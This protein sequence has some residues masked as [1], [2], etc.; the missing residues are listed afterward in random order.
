MNCREFTEF[1]NLYFDG[2]LAAAERA[3]FD[4]HLAE[5]PDCTAYLQNYAA[6]VRLGRAAFDTNGSVP[7]AVPA[8]LVAAVLAALRQ[9]P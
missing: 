2:E 1:L 8:D 6:T 9:R 5:C 7:A 4:E 3:V